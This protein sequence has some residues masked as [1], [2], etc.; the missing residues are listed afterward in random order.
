MYPYGI[1][2]K[3]SL[4]MLVLEIL[5]EYS[6]SDHRLTQM[7]IVELLEKNYGIECK[8]QTVKNNLTLLK[9]M[10]YEIS[11]Q[12]GIYLVSRK[13]EDAELRML[14]DSVLFSRTLTT[15]QAKRLIGKLESL[16]NKY[17]HAKVKHV[18]NLPELIHSDNKQV[19]LNL[20]A[21]N[22]AIEQER[23]VS[24]IYNSY[25][26]DLKLRPRRE[27]PYIVNPY[28]MVANNGRYY[29]LGNYDKYD[30]YDNVSHYR[31]DCMTYV[32]ILDAKAK[33]K[34]QVKEFA[35]GYNLP[36]HMAEHAYMF[37]GPSVQVK[38]S[39]SEGTIGQIID[40]FGKDF[41]ILQQEDDE[42][43]ISLSC[44]EMAM[45]WWA[46]QYGEFVEILEPESLRKAIRKAV[47]YMGKVYK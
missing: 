3:K 15:A 7:D 4:N 41:R 25:G 14:I 21:L 45:K 1:R 38:M 40:W 18:S 5:E 33:P 39:L 27:E 13:F 8:R 42:L 10:G 47:K 31:L 26:A 9:D 24:F 12:G 28:Q 44:N 43:I 32:Q 16:G 34:N 46:L 19:M 6:D 22:D 11:L 2:D 29:L 30:K 36:K 37:S 35:Q 20:D 23:K 17:F